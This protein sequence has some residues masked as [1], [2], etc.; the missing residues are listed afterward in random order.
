[1]PFCHNASAPE[2]DVPI[3]TIERSI[4]F[5]GRNAEVTWFHPKVG[6][7]PGADPGQAP[8]AVMCYQSITGSEDLVRSTNPSP[9][10]SA[11]PGVNLSPSIHWVDTIS[12]HLAGK[13]ACVISSPT[14]T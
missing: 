4:P 11:N 3:L 6:F 12:N 1:M 5:N 7:M 8:V 2:F 9:P 13:R 14:G 10:I